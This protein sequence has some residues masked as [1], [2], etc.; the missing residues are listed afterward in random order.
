VGEEKTG[1]NCDEK[2][3]LGTSILHQSSEL[4]SFIFAMKQKQGSNQFISF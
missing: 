3:I 4:G 1:G 2:E